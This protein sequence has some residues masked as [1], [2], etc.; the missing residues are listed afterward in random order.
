M[1]YVFLVNTCEICKKVLKFNGIVHVVH[2]H[3][4]DHVDVGFL[5]N[6]MKI[7]KSDQNSNGLQA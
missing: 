6:L 5:L 3:D 1:K 7:W 2:V 4:H